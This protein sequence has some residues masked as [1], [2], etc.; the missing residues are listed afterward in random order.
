MFQHCAGR[1]TWLWQSQAHAWV[2]LYSSKDILRPGKA[3][4]IVMLQVGILESHTFR[5]HK[6]SSWSTAGICSKVSHR[7]VLRVWIH[8]VAVSQLQFFCPIV[9]PSI[10]AQWSL[11]YK[12]QRKDM[13]LENLFKPGSSIVVVSFDKR[14]ADGSSAV[15]WAR[16][17][18]CPWLILVISTRCFWPCYIYVL[19]QYDY[20]LWFDPW[21]IPPCNVLFIWKREMQ[22]QSRANTLQE[23]RFSEHVKRMIIHWD[24]LDGTWYLNGSCSEP[25]APSP[26]L[27]AKRFEACPMRP[28]WCKTTWITWDDM[29]YIMG[30]TWYDND[31]IERD[32]T[33]W[34]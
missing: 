31:M 5:D 17:Q 7:Q 22:H 12:Q 34:L 21:C 32:R 24:L 15:Q 13:K 11:R 19:G 33:N 27:T 10:G 14:Q 18:R 30:G 8:S 20:I 6:L 28:G 23:T 1:R 4:N 16:H 3:C 29:G 26:T 9:L 2:Q 25:M